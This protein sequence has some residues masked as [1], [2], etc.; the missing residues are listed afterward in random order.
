MNAG[1]YILGVIEKVAQRIIKAREPVI[2]EGEVKA[3]NPIKIK[4][5]DYEITEEHC[6]FDIRCTEQW[7]RVPKASKYEH[8]HEID[9]E[10]ELAKT[11]G[12]IGGQATWVEPTGHKHKIKIETKTA[13]PEICLWRGLKEGDKVRIIRLEGGAVH[14]ITGRIEEHMD[15]DSEEEGGQYGTT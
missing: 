6:I 15:N 2:M 8:L 7:I 14:W 4:V 9:A 12:Q 3:T 10:T 11:D 13:L 1:D 5:N